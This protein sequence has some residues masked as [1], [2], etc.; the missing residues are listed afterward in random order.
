MKLESFKERWMGRGS[1]KR[2][3]SLESELEDPRLDDPSLRLQFG[4]QM[5]SSPQ[6]E[7]KHLDSKPDTNMNTH[8]TTDANVTTQ[9]HQ[10][11]PHDNDRVT[12]E[13][14]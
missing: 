7:N 8:T 2:S 1:P 10:P 9:Q 14:V 3:S 6:P 4:E 11:Q 13:Q 12:P 5:S